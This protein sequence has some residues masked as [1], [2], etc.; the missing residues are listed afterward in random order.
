MGQWDEPRGMQ[1]VKV[2]KPGLLDKLRANRKSHRETFLEALTG[3]HK[4][5]QKALADRVQEAKDNKRISL[6]FHLEQPTD[7]TK[8]YDRIITMLEMSVD[9]KIELTQ[10]EFANYVMDDWAWMQE[11][12]HSNRGYSESARTKLASLTSDD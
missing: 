1:T 2:E 8:E 3:Y 12:L 11:W 5:A 4:A 7:Q 10:K 6:H 9:D